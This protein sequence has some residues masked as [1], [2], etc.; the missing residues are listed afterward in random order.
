MKKIIIGIGIIIIVVGVRVLE[1]KGVELF[2][3]GETSESILVLFTLTFLGFCCR[4]PVM[5]GS[6]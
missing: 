3:S 6:T 5:T 1:E 4:L 2:I